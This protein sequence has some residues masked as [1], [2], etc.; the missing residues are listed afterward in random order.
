LEAL[1]ARSSAA[2]QAG[3]R[4]CV[5]NR[6]GAASAARAAACWLGGRQ[7]HENPGAA[8]RAH[9]AALATPQIVISLHAVTF[10]ALVEISH[11][12][13]APSALGSV[14]NVEAR[15]C[16]FVLFRAKQRTH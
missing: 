13:T 16:A 5:G 6:G 12:G 2:A 15:S 8:F 7:A 1:L 4:D 3:R 9:A 11:A 10:H 14:D